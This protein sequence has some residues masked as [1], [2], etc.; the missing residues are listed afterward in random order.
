MTGTKIKYSIFLLFCV[1]AFLGG[2]TKEDLKD[3]ISGLHLSYYYTLN[4][5]Y[6]NL[7]EQEI[8]KVTVYV[9]DEADMLYSTFSFEDPAELSNNHSLYLPLPSGKWKLV[10]LCGNL[11]TYCHGLFKKEESTRTFTPQSMEPGVT[12][13]DEFLFN[14]AFDGEKQDTILM[15]NRPT[16]LY[17][18]DYCEAETFVDRITKVNVPVIKDVNDII[19]KIPGV[20][21]LSS[22]ADVAN[23]FN[24]YCTQRNGCY[25]YDNNIRNEARVVKYQQP[26]YIVQDTL[27]VEMTVMRL[28]EDDYDGRMVI[29]SSYLPDGRYEINLLETIMKNPDFTNQEDLDR[30][31]TYEIILTMNTTITITIN[32]WE[33]IPVT[34]DPK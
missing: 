10:S 30:H 27:I 4:K 16:K 29:E 1:F 2:C 14:L 19:L 25:G 33:I 7:F 9:F 22:R 15:T 21:S 34:V 17:Y 31:D 12:M 28:M 6:T 23:H 18:G 13:L 32:G 8:D 11:E 20:S 5:E 3:C 26:A 24:V